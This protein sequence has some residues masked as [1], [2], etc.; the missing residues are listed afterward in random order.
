M[1]VNPWSAANLWFFSPAQLHF[2]RIRWRNRAGGSSKL[3][4]SDLARRPI[5]PTFSEHSGIAF[6]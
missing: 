1:G 2:R 6:G 4:T 3:D 5:A